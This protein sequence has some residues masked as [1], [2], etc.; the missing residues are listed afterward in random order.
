MNRSFY[1]RGNSKF[2]RIGTPMTHLIL[3][4]VLIINTGCF[5]TH[6]IRTKVSV[7]L[8]DFAPEDGDY[9]LN[10][11]G[12]AWTEDDK[13]YYK[14]TI[15]L[16]TPAPETFDLGFYIKENRF[17]WPDPELGFFLATFN[18]GDTRSQPSFWLVCTRK[19][20]VKGNVGKGD[21]EHAKVYLES[22]GLASNVDLDTWYWDIR[23]T[24]HEHVIRCK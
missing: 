3:L 21:D 10:C 15:E 14:A 2:V 6:E 12:E 8:I 19:C 4:C 23:A 17:L 5:H 18:Q 9:N 20:K 13:E 7:N 1:A 22:S 16:S 11:P 24:R